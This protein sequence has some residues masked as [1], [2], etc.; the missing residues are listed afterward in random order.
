M[1]IV[2][3]TGGIGSGKTEAANTFAA[4][5]V[6][7]VDLDAISHQL[8]AANKPLVSTITVAFGDEYATESGALNREKMRQL[9][10]NDDEARARL[11]SILHPAIYKKATKQL[12]VLKLE[13]EDKCE[14][15]DYAI[16]SIP[17]LAEDSPYL[18]SIDRI[19]TI[20]CDEKIQIERVK[21]RSKLKET[22][23][24]KI[25]A[26]QVPAEIRLEMADDVIKNDGNVE[27]LRKK[28]MNLHQKYIKTCIV[29]KTIS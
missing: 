18:P 9:V 7:I 12:A 2:A 19:L 1:M 21:T 15:K 11:N 16:L 6:P 25:I 3:L 10:F 14:G 23:I 26:S 5:N 13:H 28:V 24:K 8:T 27:E 4:L 20:D 29:R 22:V 17:L